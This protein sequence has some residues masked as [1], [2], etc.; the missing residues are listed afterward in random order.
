MTIYTAY[1]EIADLLSTAI[2][3]ATKA[4]GYKQIRKIK[5]PD[6]IILATA[7]QLDADLVTINDSDFKGLDPNVTI[8]IPTL[9][10]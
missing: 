2:A 1:D 10:V 7:R 4:V 9:L 6:V 5:T 8:I 3:I